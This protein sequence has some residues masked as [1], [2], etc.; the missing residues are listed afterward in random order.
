[1]TPAEYLDAAKEKLGL[2]SDYELTKRAGIPRNHISGIRS[3]K[4]AMPLELAYWIARTL[5]L[6]PGSVVADLGSQRTKNP[7]RA[8]FLRSFVQSTWSKA[9]IWVLAIAS[10]ATIAPTETYASDTL[11]V[12]SPALKAAP[13]QGFASHEIGIMSTLHRAITRITA[14]VRGMLGAGLPRCGFAGL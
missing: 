1:M 8:E 11:N 2:P 7:E 9:A 14:S 3:G 5:G 6:D 13:L 4:R 12:S 10:A